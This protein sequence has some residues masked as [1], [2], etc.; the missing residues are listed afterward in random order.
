[1]AFLS[2]VSWARTRN[3]SS[4]TLGSIQKCLRRPATLAEF[5]RLSLPQPQCYPQLWRT[6]SLSRR[7]WQLEALLEVSEAIAQQ[8][9]LPALFH[10]L[11]ERLHSVVDFDFLALTLHDQVRNVMRLHVLELRH[12]HEKRVGAESS[13]DGHPSGWV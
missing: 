2:K 8:R 10:D 9:D 3:P 7:S 5:S 11:S 4:L 1:M 12:P 13:I 6:P